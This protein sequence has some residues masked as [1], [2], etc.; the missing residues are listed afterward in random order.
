MPR[1]KNPEYEA[2]MAASKEL[3]RLN[4]KDR[5]RWKEL[6]PQVKLLLEQEPETK[7]DFAPPGLMID[8][9]QKRGPRKKKEN[10]LTNAENQKRHR[11]K[12]KAAGYR[13]VWIKGD[14]KLKS[15]KYEFVAVRLHKSSLGAGKE[16][17][18]IRMFLAIMLNMASGQ[19][20]GKFFSWDLVDDLAEF[21]K[22][23]G[24][25]NVEDA[26]LEID[27]IKKGLNAENQG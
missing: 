9:K 24:L 20:E 21:C 10:V 16:Q 13:K 18:N 1:K 26:V 23:L 2:L 8:L 27:E 19:A 5:E 6:K 11:E 4:K 7:F 3:K 15:D 25:E 14:E 12:M 22:T 17:P